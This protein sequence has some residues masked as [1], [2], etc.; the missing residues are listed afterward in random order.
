MNHGVTYPTPSNL[1][2]FW[3]FGSISGIL[4][5]SQIV[6]GIFLAMHY[7]PE[8]H[9]AFNSIE[10][11]MR[12]VTNGWLI[13]YCHTNGASLFFIFVYIHIARGLYFKSYRKKVLW[14]SGLVIFLLMM[15]SA[16]LGYVLPWGQMSLWGATVITN[17]FSALPIIGESIVTWLWG[18]FSVDNPTLKRFFVLHFLLPLVLLAITLLHLILLHEKGSTNPLGVCSKLDIVRFYP[19][20][21][22]KD[23]FGFLAIVSPLFI[24]TVFGYPNLLGHADNYIVANSLVTPKH[25]VPEWYFLPF[26]AI[27]RSIPDKLA[28]VLAMFFAI[29][30]LFLLPVVGQFKI[31]SNKVCK[32]HQIFFWLF[33]FNFIFLGFIGARVVEEPYIL[34]GRVSTSIYFLYFLVVIPMLCKLETKVN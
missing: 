6:S 11:I 12:D 30:I 7:S 14:C 19:Y 27:L 33:V 32:I 23:I 34:A 20:F 10:H 31:N 4:L 21:V 26:Y 2:Y 22:I 16:F 29:L 17:L 9:L 8:I 18:G 3:G 1:N 15:A 13:R 24:F 25:I 5:V 28:G